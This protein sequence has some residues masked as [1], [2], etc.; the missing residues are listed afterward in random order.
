MQ[1]KLS[2]KQRTIDSGTIWGHSILRM[3][4]VANGNGIFL[5]T[6]FKD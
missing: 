2:L 4:F 3:F 6:D 1:V 5:A